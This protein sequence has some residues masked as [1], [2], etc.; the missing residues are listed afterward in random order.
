MATSNSY[1][2][3][4]N[5]NELIDL[6][7][8]DLAVMEKGEIA[9]EDLYVYAGRKLNMMLKAWMSDGVQLHRK[10]RLTVFFRNDQG[11]YNISSSSSADHCTLDFH[12]PDEGNLT[13]G[14]GYTRINNSSGEVAGETSLTVDT[15][16]GMVAND[17]IMIQL[18]NGSAHW[19][20]IS[21][22]ADSTTVVIT[23]AIPVGRTGNDDATVFWYTTRAER[24]EGIMRDHAHIVTPSTGVQRTINV[25]TS[26]EF[27]RR[28]NKSSDGAVAEYYYDPRGRI[29]T[30]GRL[31]LYPQPDTV[32]DVAQFI[33]E[34]PIETMDN[35]DDDFDMDQKWF[36]AVELG[37]AVLMAPTFGV[38]GRRYEELLGQ[39]LTEKQRVM[40][41]D[42]EQESIYIHPS[43]DWWNENWPRGQG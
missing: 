32:V 12:F 21:S 35:D 38:S 2:F 20:T 17:N 1:N 24:P 33:V 9:D 3:T 36:L 42:H 19:T 13:A 23:A 14:N 10:R 4:L 18:D 7:L 30:H 41:W 27:W 25:L 37:L 28:S 6:A 31:W 15:T 26:E 43:E 29:D 22:V 5:R 34:Y 16:T 40:G 39:A 11:L 8:Q